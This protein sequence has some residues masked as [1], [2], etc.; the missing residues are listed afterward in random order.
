MVVYALSTSLPLLAFAALGPVIRRKCPEG[1][2]LTEWTRQRYGLITALFLS[3]LTYGHLQTWI[4][5]HYCGMCY[6]Y[7]LY[8]YDSMLLIHHVCSCSE[9]LAS[10][11][12]ISVSLMF[13]ASRHY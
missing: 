13:R 8:L 9:L 11:L 12:L 4:A 1:F 2:I 5:C 3:L 7:H 10:N 6:N